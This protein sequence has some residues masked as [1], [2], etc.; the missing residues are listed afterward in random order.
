MLIRM[1]VCEEEEEKEMM[2]AVVMGL[3]PGCRGVVL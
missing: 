1:W 2:M 3:S